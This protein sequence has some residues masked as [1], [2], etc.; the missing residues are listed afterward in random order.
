MINFINCTICPYSQVQG[1]P[2]NITVNDPGYWMECRRYP[3]TNG[4]IG[5]QYPR[6][7]INDWCGEHPKINL[8]SIS[9]KPPVKKKIAKKKVAKKTAAKKK[10]AKKPW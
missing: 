6:V 1:L 7:T 4:P 5:S 2:T 9:E 3:P 8:E 10:V